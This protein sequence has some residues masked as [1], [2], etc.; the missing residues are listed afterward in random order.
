MIFKKYKQ[1]NEL[2]ITYKM[3]FDTDRNGA[4]GLLR[5][6]TECLTIYIYIF[7]TECGDKIQ[8]FMQFTYW[9]K[10]KNS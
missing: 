2:L 10:K 4:N 7:F 5:Y 1:D 8:Q 6:L 3:S 9:I